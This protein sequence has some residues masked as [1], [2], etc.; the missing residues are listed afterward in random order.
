MTNDA[1]KILIVDDKPENLYALNKL[2]K[3]L[4]V[5]VSQALS[6]IDAL[7]LAL[8]HDFCVAI[9]D[10]QMPGMDGYELVELLRSNEDTA[11]LP[12]IFVSAIFS[13]EYH[14]RKGYE[15]GAVDFM[16]KPFTP[17]ILLSKVKIFMELYQQRRA[18]QQANVVL[19][20]QTLQL[21]ISSQV[22]Q[23]VTS[24][25]ELDELFRAVVKSI[26]SQFGHYFVGIWLL[27]DR[28]DKVVLRAG[29]DGEGQ[30]P[31]ADFSIALSDPENSVARVCR[32][33]EPCQIDN[34]DA[35]SE[36]LKLGERLPVRSEL[37]LPLRVGQQTIGALDIWS[38]RAAA[39]DAEDHHVLQILANQIA[40]AIGNALVYKLEKDLRSAE[41]EKAQA[42]AKLNTDKDKFFSIISHDLRSPFN[43]VLGNTR[44]LLKAINSSNKQ[45]LQEIAQSIHNGAKAVYS[46]L[47][48]LLTWAR[49]QR[50]EG[51]TWDPEALELTAVERTV[52]KVLGPVAAQKE[53][54]LSNALEAG[55]WVQADR[56][57]LETVLRNLTSNALKFTPR[58]GQVSLTASASSVNGQPGFVTVSVTD[59][60]VGMSEAV[61]ARLFRI[62]SQHS[63]VGTE[64]EPGTGL[65]L[66]ICQEMVQRNGGKIWVE[67]E[68][69]KGTVMQ[70]TVPYTTPL[71]T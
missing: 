2:L 49:M 53:I 60:G 65:G 26:Q 6:G 11:N 66:I 47:E 7:N 48:N 13:D 18:L 28:N 46:L 58:G 41:V 1:P 59:T 27:N 42:L 63:T 33:G 16:S 64:N 24:I 54:E 55:L 51:I 22:S 15:A 44:F 71:P 8:E 9:V 34:A 20:K 19:S 29:I 5:E 62:D 14:H 30:I 61:M 36:S 45:E 32:S 68:P 37:V 25:L 17:E 39:F 31:S 23:Q 3:N 70:F 69:G 12:V 4:A 52:I 56:N 38:E 67:S 40:I 21:K 35:Q 57:M 10:I 43:I 50:A